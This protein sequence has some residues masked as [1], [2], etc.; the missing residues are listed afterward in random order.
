VIIIAASALFRVRPLARS[1]IAR[2][3]MLD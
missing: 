3:M 1:F 2:A